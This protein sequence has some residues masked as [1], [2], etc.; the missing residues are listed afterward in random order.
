MRRRLPARGGGAASDPRARL[1]QPGTAND[2]YWSM[3][4]RFRLVAMALGLV[5]VVLLPFMANSVAAQATSVLSAIPAGSGAPAVLALPG[6]VVWDYDGYQILRSTDVGAKWK[7]VLPTW[8]L[9]PV[10]LQ[11]TGAFFLNAKDAWAE[12]EHQWPAQPGATTTWETTNGGQPGT[13]APRF[14]A[15]PR[16]GRQASTSSPSRTPSTASASG[17][18]PGARPAAATRSSGSAETTCGPLRTVACTGG[19][20]RPWGSPGR[21]APTPLAR[22]AGALGLTR[23]T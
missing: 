15:R 23:S 20:S 11:V 5:T 13:K 14:L 6:G 17:W 22:L 3:T 18:E 19:A 9:T 10:S 16:T 7:V 12:T 21:P 1:L 8:E 2:S 4:R